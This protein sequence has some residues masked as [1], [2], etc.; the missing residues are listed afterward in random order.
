MAGNSSQTP[1]RERSGSGPKLGL[2]AA[3]MLAASGCLT[4]ADDEGPIL[5]IELFWDEDATDSGFMGGT[6][7]SA[8]VD[9]MEWR[10]IQEGDDP[11]SEDDDTEVASDSQPCYNAI[12]V[13]DPGAG[14]YRLEISGFDDA[15]QEKWAVV[16]S[17]ME[18]LRFDV[19]YDCDIHSN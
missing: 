2:I 14:R 18:V 3:V 10:L 4:V 6:C 8:E 9:S 5:S 17:D 11:D 12:D 15:D 1:T 19:T 7:D 13:I 16:C